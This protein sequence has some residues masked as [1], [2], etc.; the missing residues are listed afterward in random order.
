MIIVGRGGGSLEDLWNF[1][2]EPV[3]RTRVLFRL[4]VL[5]VMRQMLLYRI[6]RRMYGQEH[7]QLQQ[8]LQ[9]QIGSW[10]IKNSM[11]PRNMQINVLKPLFLTNAIY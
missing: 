10:F 2:E 8:K 5:L 1:N 9:C 6:L 11:N 3:V 7:H 4:S